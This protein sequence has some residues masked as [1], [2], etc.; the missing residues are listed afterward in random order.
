LSPLVKRLEKSGLVTRAR[1]GRD[2][3]VLALTL[4]DAGRTLRAQ[5]EK[6]PD[7]IVAR[8]GL[9][10]SDL[11]HLHAVLTRVIAAADAS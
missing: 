5:A 3:R 1:D 6:V 7:Q 10:V 9:P 8:L 11:E 2:E 4:T